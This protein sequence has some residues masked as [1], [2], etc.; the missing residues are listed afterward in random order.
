MGVSGRKE[1]ET[2]YT[3]SQHVRL[4]IRAVSGLS[5]RVPWFVDGGGHLRPAGT[6][7][8]FGWIVLIDRVSVCVEVGPEQ[9]GF[10]GR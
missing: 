3:I 1:G 5:I 9:R 7:A 2:Y 10:T 8:G 4:S 6:D